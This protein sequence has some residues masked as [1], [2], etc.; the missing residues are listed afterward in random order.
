MVA[1]HLQPCRECPGAIRRGAALDALSDA[2]YWAVATLGEWRRRTRERGQLAA[3]DARLLADIGL[4]HA[5]REMLVNKPF[6]RE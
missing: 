3:L 5:D 2:A 1:V 6:W 4:T